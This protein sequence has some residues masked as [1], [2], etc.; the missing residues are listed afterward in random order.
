MTET[1]VHSTL[2]RPA[3]KL[4]DR[5][6]VS[7][8]PHRTIR[9][10]VAKGFSLAICCKQCSRMIEWTPQDLVDRFGS[11]LDLP[12]AELVPKLA[13]TGREGCGSKEVAV[14]PHFY[15]GEWRWPPA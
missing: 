1:V 4:I 12:L 6:D 13:C 15:D 3:Q 10:L 5:F 8:M 11:K 14:F 2:K 9:M 7:K